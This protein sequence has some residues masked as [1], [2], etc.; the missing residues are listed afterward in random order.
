MHTTTSFSSDVIRIK[1]VS[2]KAGIAISS[3]YNK[4]NPDSKYHDPKFPRPIRLG[5]S[6]V[7]W[8]ESE[9]DAWIGSRQ[10]AQ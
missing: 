10:R 6:S 7:G 5:T 9:V 1:R 2:K 8:I 3:I 4:L